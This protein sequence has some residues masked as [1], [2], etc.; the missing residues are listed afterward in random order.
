MILSAGD[1][2]E[3]LVTRISEDTPHRDYDRTVDHAKWCYQIITGDD[4]KEI[5]VTYK[6]RETQKQVDQRI[7]ITNSR[8]QYVSNKVKKLYNEVHRCDDVVESISYTSPNDTGLEALSNALNHWYE[9]KPLKKY[10]NNRFKDLVF[11]DPNA[12]IIIEFINDDPVNKKPT[13]YPFEV[14]ADEVYDHKYVNGVLKYLI[15]QHAVSYKSKVK[16]QETI[17]KRYTMYG[18]GYSYV[19]QH[20]PKDA[21]FTTPAGWEEIII[22]VGDQ[23][24]PQKYI[25]K[26]YESKTTECPAFRVGYSDDPQTRGRTKV[27]PM[28]PAEKIITDLIWNKS[29]YDLSKALHGFYQKFAYVDN[30]GVCQGE[31]H[32]QNSENVEVQCKV[33][34]GSGKDIHSTVQDIITL[35]MPNDKANMIPLSDL[36]YYA[37]IPE[38]LIKMQREDFVTD[39]RDVFNAIFGANV[40]DRSEI[41]ETATAKNYD[42]RAVNNTLFEYADQVSEFFKFTVR[43][44]A[45]HIG[46]ADKLAVQHSFPSDF[47]LESVQELIDQ[48][49][50]AQTA[51]VPMSAI[52]TIDLAILSKQHKDDPDYVKNYKAW[53]RFK[54]MKD[55]SQQERM[56]LLTSTLPADDPERILYLYYERIMADIFDEY[57]NFADFDYK[58]QREIVYGKVN[59]IKA[60]QAKGKP[61]L[62]MALKADQNTD[63]NGPESVQ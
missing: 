44:T 7:R 46:E 32:Y 50:A 58:K 62:S 45:N 42:W 56:V 33:C 54:P 18:I 6:V 49:S 24:T 63:P 53:E 11:E 61:T 51:G 47:K 15:T 25:W 20:V 34:K 16:N 60:E 30:C 26:G 23:K 41:V 57:A 52:S 37:T 21:V 4:Q 12:Y 1:L 13:V 9:D 10:I 19:M 14:R 28:Y 55:K 2:L 27:S 40:L 17:G 31:G 5:L 3:I 22:K 39:Q 36:V 29:E 38:N 48:R 59:V 8:T 43:T 35:K